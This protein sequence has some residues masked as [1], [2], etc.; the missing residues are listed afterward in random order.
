MNMQQ[1]VPQN[2]RL[3]K[4]EKSEGAKPEFNIRNIP[5]PHVIKGR[6]DEYVIG[7]D[8]AKK[9]I[10]VAVYN[11]YKRVAGDAMDDIQIE[12]SNILMGVLQPDYPRRRGGGVGGKQTG[13]S[14]A[15]C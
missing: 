11:H 15:S 9:V 12:K 6:L 14:R 10:S 8:Y 5:A 1:S 2:Q 3:K 13:T 4:Q 7:Q